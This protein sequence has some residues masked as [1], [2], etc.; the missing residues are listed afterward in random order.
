[1][2]IRDRNAL[3]AAANACRQILPDYLSDPLSLEAI[4][5]FFRQYYWARGNYDAKDILPCLTD[6]GAEKLEFQ[7]QSAAEFALIDSPTRAVVIPWQ[8]EGA[9]LCTALR[10]PNLLDEPWRVA[11]LARAA[12]RYSVNVWPDEFE[13]L[14]DSGRIEPVHQE[15][16]LLRDLADYSS[17]TGLVRQDASGDVVTEIG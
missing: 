11:K 5:D 13:Q 3:R 16:W 6:R 7:F 2:C 4:D 10:Q 14:R 1:M 9:D 8:A 17:V 12:Q 15:W